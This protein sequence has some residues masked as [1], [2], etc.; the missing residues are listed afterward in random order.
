MAALEL[1]TQGNEALAAGH[2]SQACALYSQAIEID[3]SNHARRPAPNPT[4]AQR[5]PS[6]GPR[7]VAAPDGEAIRGADDVAPLVERHG[8]AFGRAR[9]RADRAA[10]GRVSARRPAAR[11]RSLPGA[12]WCLPV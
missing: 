11:A 5:R 6:L 3:G 10:A 12:P 9:G 2:Y 7:A 8:A 1:K 4:P